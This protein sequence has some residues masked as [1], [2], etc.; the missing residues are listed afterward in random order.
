MGEK[1]KNGDSDW[2]QSNDEILYSEKIKDVC[3]C[4]PHKKTVSKVTVQ[5]KEKDGGKNPRAMSKNCS[6][7]QQEYGIC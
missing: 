3:H 5:Q 7:L 2:T 4:Y 1:I 6:Q